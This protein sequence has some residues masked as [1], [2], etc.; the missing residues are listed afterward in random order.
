MRFGLMA[1]AAACVVAT[2][3]SAAVI[4]GTVDAGQTVD[5]DS[6]VGV[7]RALFRFTADQAIS[8]GYRFNQVVVYTNYDANGDYIDGND[9]LR[10]P[11]DSGGPARAF[12]LV[13]KD[14]PYRL[15]GADGGYTLF[16]YNNYPVYFTI[17][18]NSLAAASFRIEVLS[19]PGGVPEPA[20][21]ALMI[22]GFGA[23]GGAMRR[24]HRQLQAA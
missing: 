14:G 9:N 18:N 10:A 23:V 16:T 20:A 13:Y 24:R 12:D 8:G 5:F 22:M 19:I 7:S 6:G 17:T 4:N 11:A 2:P 1:A 15:S 21:W 3:A